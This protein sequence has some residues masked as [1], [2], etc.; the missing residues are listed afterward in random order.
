MP[1]EHT[2]RREAAARQL[3]RLVHYFETTGARIAILARTLGLPLR[4]AAEINAVLNGTLT[5]PRGAASRIGMQDELRALLLMQYQAIARL[6]NS[7]QVGAP[8]TR[9]ILCIVCSRLQ[10]RGFDATDFLND[11]IAQP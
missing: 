8:A 6:A 9:D 1:T 5:S 2:P 11:L 4:G 7:A 3:E 10:Q